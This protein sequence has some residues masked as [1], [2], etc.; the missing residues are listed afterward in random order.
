MAITKKQKEVFDYIRSYNAKNGYAPT[1]REI[2]EHFDLKSFGSVQRYIKYLT[3]SGHLESDWNARRGL[4]I[5]E[6]EPAFPPADSLEIPLL[7]LVAAGNPILALENPTET[8]A[9]PLSM[10]RPKGQHFALR[11][12]GDSMIEDGILEDDIIICQHQST[13]QN[14]ERVVAVID[15]EATVKK[16]Y[17]NRQQIELH[18]ANARLRPIMIGPDVTDFKIAGVVVGLLRS[19]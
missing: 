18:P 9:I 12:K 3:D 8:V 6:D 19:Y 2:K 15:G 16:F 4:V 5:K 1:Q 17:K 14:G 11:V 10:I 7:G 13:A